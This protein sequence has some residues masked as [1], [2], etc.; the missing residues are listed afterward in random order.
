VI[1]AVYGFW[2]RRVMHVALRSGCT[3]ALLA[4]LIFAV[5]D[6]HWIDLAWTADRW[7]RLLAGSR[8]SFSWASVSST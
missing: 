1:I 7:G 4:L 6:S 2:L 5:C 3:A 8:P